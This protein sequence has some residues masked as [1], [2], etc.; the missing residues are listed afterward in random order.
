M[1]TQATWHILIKLPI[2]KGAQRAHINTE[3]TYIHSI[4]PVYLCL[5]TKKHVLIYELTFAKAACQKK[6]FQQ[7]DKFSLCA[8]KIL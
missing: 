4:Y 1:A 2:V 7:C 5:S 8:K 6:L 3:Y